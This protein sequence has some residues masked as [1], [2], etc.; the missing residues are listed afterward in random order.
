MNIS[1][2][3]LDRFCDEQRGSDEEIGR[4]LE[5]NDRPLRSSAAGLSDDELIVK[6]GSFG[7]HFDREQL[8]QLCA[9]A[10]SAEEVARP[11]IESSWPGRHRAPGR[12]ALR[13]RRGV[14]GRGRGRRCGSRRGSAS[15][16][17]SR[18]RPPRHR[19]RLAGP[20]CPSLVGVLRRRP[21]RRSAGPVRRW[22]RGW[23]SAGHGPGSH[24]HRPRSG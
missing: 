10:L 11:L 16:P 13:G 23:S 18:S 22:P 14:R 15:W 3:T 7:L 1:W 19:V 20:R 8:E 5:D 12:A 2:V 21:G 24:L 6:L 17:G 4:L 9:G